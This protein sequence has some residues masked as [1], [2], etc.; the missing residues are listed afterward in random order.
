MTVLILP[1]RFTV[2]S[3]SLWEAAN[4]EIVF[5]GEPMFA[6][7]VADGL[8]IALLEP[9]L[10]WLTT[11]PQSLLGR[12]V[13]FTTLGEARRLERPSFVKPADD[14]CFKPRVF[15]SGRELPP[16]EDLGELMV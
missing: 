11:I 16:E 6:G 9:P 5:Y 14:K 3:N 10:D 15:D 4:D 8:P 7:V 12:G 1:P 2:D 13:R